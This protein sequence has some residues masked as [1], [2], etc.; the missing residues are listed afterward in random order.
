M[1]IDRGIAQKKMRLTSERI[2]AAGTRTGKVGIGMG[3][4]SGYIV[5]GDDA[6]RWKGD[7]RASEDLRGV[8]VGGGG[9]DRPTR[10]G[11]RGE[12]V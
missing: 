3:L 8:E 5:G 1:K 2:N 6:H 11:R 9:D 7:G 12:G 4:A 10:G